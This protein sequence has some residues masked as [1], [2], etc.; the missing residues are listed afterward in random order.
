MIISRTPYRVSFFGGGTDYPEWYRTHGGQVLATTIDKYLYIT[1]RYLPP[2]FEHRLR[3]VYT[4]TELCQSCEELIHPTARETLGFLDLKQDLEI[5]YDGDLPGRSGIGSSSAFT[6]GL[7][8]ALYRYKGEQVASDRLAHESIYIEQQLVGEQVGSQDQVSA[9]F[10]GLNKITFLLNGE[11]V[12]EP[13]AVERERV[14]YLNSHFMLFYT[15]ISRTAAEVAETYVS[16]IHLHREPLFRM[17]AMVD[18]AVDILRGNNDLDDFGRLLHEAW[19]EKRTLSSKISNSRINEIYSSA[20]T[21]GAI[22]GKLSGAG[23]GGMLL[24][25][26]PPDKQQK[27]KDVLSDLIHVP[28]NFE[29]TGSKII[30][31]DDGQRYEE[32]E[33]LRS[34]ENYLFVDSKTSN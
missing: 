11:I 17:H 32:S 3:L 22:G 10:G 1:C 6:V 26:V 18:S 19:L 12:V 30:F 23:G 13:I 29:N 33:N 20:Q 28:F 4:Q 14:A 25:Y 9:A 15:G 2:F 34:S 21:A 16:N 31:Q 8:N 7:L 5:H 24:L 27:V